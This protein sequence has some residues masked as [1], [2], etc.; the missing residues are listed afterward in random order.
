MDSQWKSA[1][2]STFPAALPDKVSRGGRGEK[3]TRPGKLE[4]ERSFGGVHS[5]KGLREGREGWFLETV[6]YNQ[7]SARDSGGGNIEC[8]IFILIPISLSL[9]FI[10]FS[11]YLS[12]MFRT[13]IRFNT[14]Y[15][16]S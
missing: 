13:L 10:L 5:W 6:A 15:N 8:Q 4:T 11:L 9:I 1:S 3:E 12:Q 16:R 7:V 14:N 2:I